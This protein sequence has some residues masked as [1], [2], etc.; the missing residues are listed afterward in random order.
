MTTL[1]EIVDFVF[2]R[3]GAGMAVVVHIAAFGGREEL[4]QHLAEVVGLLTANRVPC[5]VCIVANE[6]VVG[7]IGVPVVTLNLYP[8]LES[9]EVETN[10]LGDVGRGYQ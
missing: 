10:G 8:D 2:K 7:V 4:E 5:S 1:K 3:N 9:I 6:P